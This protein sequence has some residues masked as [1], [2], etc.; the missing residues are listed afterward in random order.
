MLILTSRE[1]KPGWSAWKYMYVLI[2]LMFWG[3]MLAV[4]LLNRRKWEEETGNSRDW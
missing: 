1:G 4:L 2:A 3:G